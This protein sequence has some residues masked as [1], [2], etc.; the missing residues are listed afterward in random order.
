MVKRQ[1]WRISVGEPH[2]VAEVSEAL[3]TRLVAELDGEQV[4]A[5]ILKGSCARGEE[6]AYSDVDLTVFVRSEPVRSFHQRFY[7]EGRLISIGT[8]TFE[9]Y[10]RCFMQPEEAIFVVP[11]TREARILLDK[12][13]LFRQLQQEARDWTWE[14]LQEAANRYACE[15]MLEQTEIA[16]KVLRA[17]RAGSICV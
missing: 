1:F 5:I 7:R 3:L 11:S 13:G 4:T 12:E 8:H 10:H 9:Y 6:T 14:P 2:H 15:T 16:L 17:W